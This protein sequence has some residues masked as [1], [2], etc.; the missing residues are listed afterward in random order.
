MIGALVAASTLH[1]LFRTTG[2]DLGVTLPTGGWEQAFGVEIV[3]TFV[4][5]Y[6]VLAVGHERK[7]PLALV[8]AAAGAVVGLELIAAG[9]I[10]GASMN[11]ARSFRPATIGWAW[12]DHWIY[13]AA[14]AIGAGAAAFL[15]ALVAPRGVRG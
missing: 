8:A 3:L 4:L 9:S 10:S 7:A 2:G 13:W 11:P 14:P 6:V 12:Q 1:G 15:H 5:M